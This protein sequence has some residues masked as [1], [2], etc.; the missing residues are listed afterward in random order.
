MEDQ[1][2]LWT[3]LLLQRLPTISEC[4]QVI[5]SVLPCYGSV[6]QQD[7]VKE[8]ALLLHHLW[9]KSFTYT[10]LV[11]FK[12][13]KKKLMKHLKIYRNKVQRARGNKRQNMIVWSRDNN[14]LLDLLNKNADPEKF[15][16]FEKD[17]YFDQKSLTRKI[18]KMRKMRENYKKKM[19]KNYK[20][21]CLL[22]SK[23][24]MLR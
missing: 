4:V 20:K 5:V 9:A 17:F 24:N 12:T 7:T 6:K 16:K 2:D 11:T 10:Y 15:D 22:F 23:M 14:K 1:P 3:F 21:K 8:F 19:R 13:V 18:G